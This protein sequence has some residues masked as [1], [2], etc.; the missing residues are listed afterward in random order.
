M[1]VLVFFPPKSM[2]RSFLCLPILSM[3]VL[4][5]STCICPTPHS[6]HRPNI[7]PPLGFWFVPDQIRNSRTSSDPAGFRPDSPDQI[8][9]SRISSGNSGPNPAPFGTAYIIPFRRRDPVFPH[10]F[11]LPSSPNPK[12]VAPKPVEASPIKEG[13]LVAPLAPMEG[14]L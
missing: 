10:S 12:T 8:R 3:L 5:L 1:F 11:P 2:T 13:V 7:F 4:I 14:I 6:V 9:P